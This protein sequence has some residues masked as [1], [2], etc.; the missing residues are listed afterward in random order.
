M[1]IISYT[2]E[3]RTR[4]HRFKHLHEA[5]AFAQEV[6]AATGIVVAIEYQ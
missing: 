1:Y 3:G 4:T 2:H 5:C 6:F